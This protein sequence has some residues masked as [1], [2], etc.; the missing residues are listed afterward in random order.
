MRR[1]FGHQPIG[2]RLQAPV[3]LRL[4]RRVRF[5]GQ[6]G[7][8]VLS[9]CGRGPRRAV[10]AFGF[11]LRFD[12]QF[13]LRPDVTPLDTQASRAVDADESAGAPDFFRIESNRAIVEG[14][15]SAVSISASRWSTS[16][17]T[18]SASA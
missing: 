15:A 13:V 12:R 7:L 1:Q 10:L 18:S 2:D 5:R 8:V 3:F 11:G 16:S 9:P 17:G 14:A 4:G 6:G